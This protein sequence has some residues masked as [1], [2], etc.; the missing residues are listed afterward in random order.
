MCLNQNSY[1]IWNEAFFRMQ[2]W[3]KVFYFSV[4]KMKRED[5]WQHASNFLKQTVFV[6]KLTKIIY[7]EYKIIFIETLTPMYDL[8]K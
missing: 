7:L 3:P 4:F 2:E 5:V 6:G 8:A 1:F